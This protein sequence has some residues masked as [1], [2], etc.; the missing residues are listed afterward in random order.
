MI[1]LSC[2][3]EPKQ[4]SDD[5]LT[6]PLRRPQ[7]HMASETAT[8]IATG[9]HVPEQPSVFCSHQSQGACSVSQPVNGLYPVWLLLLLMMLGIHPTFLYCSNSFTFCCTL[10]CVSVCILNDCFCG[11]HAA[12]WCTPTTAGLLRGR[13]SVPALSSFTII[14]VITLYPDGNEESLE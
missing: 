10:P 7:V 5:D 11:S 6:R 12:A 2:P 4:P 14:M 8:E 1:D 9:P 3:W 13:H